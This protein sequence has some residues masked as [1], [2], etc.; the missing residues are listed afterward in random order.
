VI[1]AEYREESLEHLEDFFEF[2]PIG[3]HV[4]DSRGAIQRANIAELE[5]L[6]FFGHADE[7]VGRPQTSLFVDESVGAQL[8]ARAARGEV[9]NNFLTAMKA[10]DGS[11]ARVIVDVNARRADDGAVLATRW[12]V[13]PEVPLELPTPRAVELSDDVAVKIAKM[14]PAEKA[15]WFD[16]LND[17]FDNAPVGVHFVGLNGVM[18]RANRAEVALLGYSDDPGAYIG[19]H[20]R[21]IH[22]ET[23]VVESLLQRLIEGIPVISKEAYLKRRG[24]GLEPVLIYSGLRLKGGKFQNTRCF[25]FSNPH[26]SQPP[27]ATHVTGYSWPRN[28]EEVGS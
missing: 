13:R 2:A 24:G 5:I 6:G 20:V 27:T 19:R 11:E 26:P 7:L 23:A 4:T 12:F 8:C 17:F 15:Q 1:K 3:M 22:H 18:M 9:V 25:L 10:R 16:V 14:S 28:E 21:H